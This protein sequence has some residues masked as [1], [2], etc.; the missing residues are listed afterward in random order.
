MPT[1]RKLGSV[2]PQGGRQTPLTLE[3]E[4]LASPVMQFALSVYDAHN[5]GMIDYH[6]PN[7]NCQ[8]ERL[9]GINI[10]IQEASDKVTQQSIF[11]WQNKYSNIKTEL[12]AT[13]VRDL[14]IERSGSTIRQ[15][16]RPA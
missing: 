9:G 5:I 4:M 2:C 15:G 14:L 16:I 12:A 11:N 13:F 1:G 6:S 10:N 7:R 8:R 3:P